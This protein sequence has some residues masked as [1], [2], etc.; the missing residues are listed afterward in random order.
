MARPVKKYYRTAFRGTSFSW[1]DSDQLVQG[2]GNINKEGEIP[3]A[4]NKYEDSATY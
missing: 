3:C 4:K 2:R 1:K